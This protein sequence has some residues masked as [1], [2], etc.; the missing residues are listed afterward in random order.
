MTTN[1]H[2]WVD[3]LDALI[4]AIQPDSILSRTFAKNEHVKA[5]LFAFDQGQSL[6]EHQAA[7]PAIL[8]ILSG[9]AKITLGDET[10]QAKAG[11]WAYMPPALKHSVYAETPLTMLLLLLQTK[12][13][14]Q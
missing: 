11:S 7:Q 10:H 12:Q 6:S 2:Q 13:S 5:V 14:A 1:V 8:H 4:G 3:N 9:E